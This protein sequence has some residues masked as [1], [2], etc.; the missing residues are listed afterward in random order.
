MVTLQ[1]GEGV[2]IPV[3]IIR[4]GGIL[5][6]MQ[7]ESYTSPG[8]PNEEF[9]GGI[10]VHRFASYETQKNFTIIVRPDGVPEVKYSI[11]TQKAIVFYLLLQT[12]LQR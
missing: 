2:A 7:I 3:I 12:V 1:E 11:C 6:D 9:Y 10:V 8:D 5:K 4:S